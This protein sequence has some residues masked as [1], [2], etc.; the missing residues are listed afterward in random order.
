MVHELP[1]AL[2]P[3][4]QADTPEQCRSPYDNGRLSG[5]SETE[6]QKGTW[7]EVDSNGHQSDSS[8]RAEH[9]TKE[10]GQLIMEVNGISMDGHAML[11]AF[12]TDRRKF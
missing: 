1:V 10:I 12:K 2:H 3:R 11:Q 9:G 5:F 8:A 4:L 7:K 6:D